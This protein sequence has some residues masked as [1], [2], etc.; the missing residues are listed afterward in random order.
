MDGTL[1]GRDEQLPPGVADLVD[2][3]EGR[4]IRFSIA[5]GRSEDFMAPYAAAMGLRCP[6]IA[7]NGATLM[8]GPRALRRKQ[9]P[10]AQ[11]RTILQTAE[12]M[13]FSLIF[14]SNGVD[15]IPRLTPWI[16]KEGRKYGKT[17]TAQPFTEAD[18][19]AYRIEKVLIMD[20]VR[21]GRIGAIEALCKATPGD[22][23]YVRYRDKAVELMER[24]A[25]KATAL[26]ELAKLLDIPMSDILAVGDDDNDIQMFQLAGVSAAV[27]NVSANARP[28]AH[29]VCARPQFDGVLE[30]VARFCPEGE[31]RP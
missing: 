9:F 27:S 10:I 7:S 5:T 30:A 18:W 31:A 12:D 1:I 25:T 23:S 28:F 8:D 19:A 11:V 20:D 13:G 24:T 29:Y 15:R 3:L 21:D 22:F 6:Y 4:G 17:Y 2:G 14:T 26:V 16:E